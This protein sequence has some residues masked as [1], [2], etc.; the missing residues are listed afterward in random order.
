MRR[1]AATPH[2][3]GPAGTADAE[4]RG[5]GAGAAGHY[6]PG[7]RPQG[8]GPPGPHRRRPRRRARVGCRITP[9]LKSCVVSVAVGLSVHLVVMGCKPRPRRRIRQRVPSWEFVSGARNRKL[10][11]KRMLCLGDGGWM[12]IMSMI[13]NS[14]ASPQC[15]WLLPEQLPRSLCDLSWP[16]PF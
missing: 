3:P 6:R 14:V 12:S 7:A 9:P 13:I 4:E 11:L 10:H 1:G 8:P 5:A 15:R 16:P 2:D